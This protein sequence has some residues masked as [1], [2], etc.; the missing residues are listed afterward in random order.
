M[1][2]SPTINKTILSE[3]IAE[4]RSLFFRA[5]DLSEFSLFVAGM[6]AFVGLVARMIGVWTP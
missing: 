5:G 1:N 4:T 3:A 2:P 6:A